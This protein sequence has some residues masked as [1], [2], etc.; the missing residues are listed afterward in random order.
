[1]SLPVWLQKILP[2]ST[3]LTWETL[4]PHLPQGLYLGGGTAVAVHL[5][6]RSS[7]DLDFFYHENAVD[8]GVWRAQLARVGPVAVIDESPGTLNAL[9][10]QT[11]IQFLHADEEQKQHLLETPTMVEGIP[12]AGLSDLL[13]MKLAA[14]SGRAQLRDYFDIMCIEQQAGRT[15]EEGLALFRGRYERPPDAS[16][17]LPIIRALGHLDD[18]E[19][20]K[21]LPV[22]KIDIA[23]YWQNRQ[24]A[25]IRNI[26]RLGAG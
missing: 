3:A 4:A 15:V 16:T 10:S 9:F 18:V 17:V 19:D 20:D 21:S 13:A 6:H 24:P 23:R 7:R 2:P 26:E 22:S 8:L 14:V 25:I 1:M 11:R 12:I 5:Q